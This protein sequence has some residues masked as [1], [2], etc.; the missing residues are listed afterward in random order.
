MNP[1]CAKEPHFYNLFLIFDNDFKQIKKYW[2][3]CTY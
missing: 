1:A 3:C 2:H